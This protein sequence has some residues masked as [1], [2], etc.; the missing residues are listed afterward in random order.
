MA[1]FYGTV[2]GGRG[3]A[4]RAGHKSTGLVVRAKTWHTQVVTKL[5]CDSDGQDFALVCVIDSTGNVKQILFNGPLG[6]R[7]PPFKMPQPT[8]TLEEI[9]KAQAEIAAS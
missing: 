5:W 1:H 6:E 9:E 4:H 7:V 2:Q 8:F 3:E